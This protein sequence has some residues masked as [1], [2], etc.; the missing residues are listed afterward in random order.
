[1]GLHCLEKYLGNHKLLQADFNC[2][3]LQWESVGVGVNRL[4]FLGHSGCWEAR[5]GQ[6]QQGHEN[7]L[8]RERALGAPETAETAGLPPT[9][10]LSLAQWGLRRVLGWLC[11]PALLSDVTF[12]FCK[13]LEQNL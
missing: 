9:V 3:A 13:T 2:Q 4:V 1:M 10:M 5:L 12:L 11:S 6:G 8:W 7:V